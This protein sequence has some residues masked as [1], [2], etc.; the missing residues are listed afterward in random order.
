MTLTIKPVQKTLNQTIKL[1]IND[2][3]EKNQKIDLI[4]IKKVLRLQ[5]HFM[6]DLVN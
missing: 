6:W 4:A 5:D 3:N 2:K 1:T